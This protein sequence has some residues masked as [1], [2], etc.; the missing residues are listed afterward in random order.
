MNHVKD[1]ISSAVEIMNGSK[2]FSDISSYS[3]Q[4]KATQKL[5][6]SKKSAF[7]KNVAKAP[8]HFAI[9]VLLHVGSMKNNSLNFFL[10]ITVIK[11]LSAK[12]IATSPYQHHCIQN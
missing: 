5:G 6:Q 1:K 12:Y 7:V 3:M 10:G 2:N 9:P 4:T 11:Y 8:G